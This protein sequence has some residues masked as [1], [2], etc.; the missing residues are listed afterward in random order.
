MKIVELMTWVAVAPIGWNSASAA[1]LAGCYGSLL[2][3][4]FRRAT[5]WR[6]RN[7]ICAFTLRRS[8]AAHFS[9]SFHSSGGILRRKGLRDSAATSGVER[10]GIDDGR[11]FRVSTEHDQ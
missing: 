4:P 1:P 9:M 6:R 8:S 11:G 2:P 7:S 3:A 10:A 5:A